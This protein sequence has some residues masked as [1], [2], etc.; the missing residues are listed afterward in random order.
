MSSQ[1]QGFPDGREI[2]L[3]FLFSCEISINA[4]CVI[5]YYPF[6]LELLLLVKSRID[7][8]AIH[9]YTKVGSVCVLRRD[10]SSQGI[11]TYRSLGTSVQSAGF[12]LLVWSVGRD[13]SILALNRATLQN[14]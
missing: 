11:G 3:L 8:Q 9:T 5:S 7:L 10:E 1:R 12:L 14:T 13:D 6:N 2:V 4:T